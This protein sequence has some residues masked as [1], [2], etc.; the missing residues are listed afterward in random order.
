MYLWDSWIKNLI[1]SALGDIF[2][3]TQLKLH[4]H[5]R[6]S[7]DY[8]FTDRQTGLAVTRWHVDSVISNANHPGAFMVSAIYRHCG[9]SQNSRYWGLR[10]NATPSMF[11]RF[12]VAG[13][14]FSWVFCIWGTVMR[15]AVKVWR[16]SIAK[17]QYQAS[18]YAF[19]RKAVTHRVWT[20]P[21]NGN[22][23]LHHMNS[24]QIND[25]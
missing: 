4:S 9:D 23:T 10:W 8:R 7:S 6:L 2:G 24:S 19:Y 17:R 25:L 22:F 11:L 5:L 15:L 18:F 3:Y 16:L 1:L 13:G 12:A 20:S 14:L 21:K